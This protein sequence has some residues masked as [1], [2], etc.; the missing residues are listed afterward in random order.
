MVSID[1]DKMSEQSG[2]STMPAKRRRSVRLQSKES[3]NDENDEHP[4]TIVKIKKESKIPLVR[5]VNMLLH[6]LK[7]MI[8]D[9]ILLIY[10]FRSTKNA[11]QRLGK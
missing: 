5:L 8:F 10:P 3:C 2:A 9:V 1:D 6:L 11:S 4:A 7:C